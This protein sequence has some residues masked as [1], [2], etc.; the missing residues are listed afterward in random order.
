MQNFSF[1]L[2]TLLPQLRLLPKKLPDYYQRVMFFCVQ[3][4]QNV[5]VGFV[6]RHPL[7]FFFLRSSIRQ[8]NWLE[9]CKRKN[10]ALFV[11]LFVFCHYLNLKLL[12]VQRK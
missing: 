7:L 1:W 4:L 8:W 10:T 2:N 12:M 3:S 11:K 6:K 5:I 9:K